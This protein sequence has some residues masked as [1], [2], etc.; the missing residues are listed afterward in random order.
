M[1]NQQNDYVLGR[2]VTEQA[3]ARE[4]RGTAVVSFRVSG[5]EF[6]A[7]SELADSQGKTVSQ[8]AR[9]AFRQGLTS[10][11]PT[12]RAAM[13][14]PNGVVAYFGDPDDERT[15]GTGEPDVEKIRQESEGLQVEVGSG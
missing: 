4:S 2:D 8:V 6:D 3:E 11:G 5:D 12:R 10:A 7:L 14:F 15:S 9:E 13:S 1:V